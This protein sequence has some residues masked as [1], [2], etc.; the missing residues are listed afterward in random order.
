MKQNRTHWI[1]RTQV[2][3]LAVLAGCGGG[4]DADE[5]ATPPP[6]V[7]QMNCA[8]VTTSALSTPGLVVTSAQPVAATEAGAPRAYPAHC[9]VTGRVNERVGVGG[10]AYAIGFDLRLPASGWNGKI[11]YLGDGGLAGGLSTLNDLPATG[12]TRKSNPLM[13]G[14]AIAS[15]DGGHKSTA[16]VALLDGEFGVDPQARIDYG[17]NALGTMTPLA[18]AIVAKFYGS[19]P[20]RAYYYGCS[21]GGQTGMQA[22]ARYA[23]Q[24][25]GIVA[26]DPGF[27]LPKSGVAAMFDNQQ[28]ASVNPAIAKAF[29]AADLSLV[30]SAIRA[31]CDALDG[32]ADGMALDLEAC[33]AAFNFQRDVPQCASGTSPDGTCLSAQQKTALS[34]IMAGAKTSGGAQLYSDWPWDPGISS[35]SWVGWKTSMN[36]TLSPTAMANVFTTPPTPGVSAFAPSADAYWRD[37]DVDR[38]YELIYGTSGI[39]TVSAMDFM[40]PPQMDTLATLKRSSKLLVYHGAA[41]GIFSVNDTIGWYNR[42]RSNDPGAAAYARLF[43]VPGMGHCSGGPSTDQ[44][45][46]F[47]ALVKWVE[48][49]E[50]PERIVAA[51]STTNVDKPASWPLTRSRP[52][53]AYPAKAVLRPGAV[54]FESADSF[55]CE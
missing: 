23:D 12:S 45:D 34:A 25:D 21:K 2:A 20:T 29:S 52:L 15:S 39:Y 33:K 44:F 35:S 54:D 40:L 47:T 46:A 14:Y 8:D 18:K 30:S 27:N 41:D 9:Y 13:E 16:V 1:I 3:T 53:C 5:V 17:Y 36:V 37:F 10:K 49:G 6:T 55:V 31:K 48:Q 42:L 22:A 26:G 11:L 38:S 50:A 28:L 4:G 19:A 32:A 51:V 43:V 7:M 24:F